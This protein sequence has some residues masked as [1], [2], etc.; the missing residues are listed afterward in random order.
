MKDK[1]TAHPDTDPSGGEP[2]GR[3]VGVGK[4]QF[5]LPRSRA[6]RMLL[7]IAFVFGGMLGF[8]PIVGFWMIPVGL[9]ILSNDVPRIRRWRRRLAVRWGKRR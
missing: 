8:L 1:A 3:L 2:K 5:R 6:M 7:G 4:W 9:L